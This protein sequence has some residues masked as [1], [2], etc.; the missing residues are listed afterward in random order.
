M[1]PY[2]DEVVD[3]AFGPACQPAGG[4]AMSTSSRQFILK[5]GRKSFLRQSRDA[6]DADAV[7][8]FYAARIR[9]EQNTCAAIFLLAS[10]RL[11]LHSAAL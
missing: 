10:P 9:D 4:S 5:M 8:G 6:A 3:D 2:E 7:A 11:G 1:L